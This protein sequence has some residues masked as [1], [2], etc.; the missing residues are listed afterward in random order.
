M[1]NRADDQV[2]GAAPRGLAAAAQL[3]ATAQPLHRRILAR[4][5]QV[6]GIGTFYL[7]ILIFFSI[8]APNFAQYSNTINILSNVSVIGIIAIGQAICIISGG[9]D[10]SV[11]GTVPLGAV[12]YA[13]MVNRP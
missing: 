8:S 9:F 7:V 4:G 1:A 6:L 12:A 13:A 10:L 11:S 5:I 2:S 3:A